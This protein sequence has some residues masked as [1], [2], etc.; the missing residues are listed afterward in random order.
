M[1]IPLDVLVRAVEALEAAQETDE[2]L[3]LPIWNKVMR[4]RAE[5]GGYVTFIA[6][7]QKVEVL[8]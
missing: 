1:T 4:A 3:P 8:A 6:R 5:L 7:A 2:R